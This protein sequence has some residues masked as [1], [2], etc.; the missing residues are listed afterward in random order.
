MTGTKAF[1]VESFGSVMSEEFFSCRGD[2]DVGGLPVGLTWLLVGFVV[3]STRTTKE[4][5]G[6]QYNFHKDQSTT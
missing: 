3:Q 6:V 2:P 5:R 1:D 4:E